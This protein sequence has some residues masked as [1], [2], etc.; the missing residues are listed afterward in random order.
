MVVLTLDQRVADLAKFPRQIFLEEER[1]DVDAL[2]LVL[3]ESENEVVP[4]FYK[5]DWSKRQ[6]K[7]EEP[8]FVKS[9]SLTN[10][11]PI[12]LA[13]VYQMMLQSLVENGYFVEEQEM[14]SILLQPLAANVED[15][16]IYVD[17]QIGHLKKINSP[18]LQ[19]QRVSDTERGYR[20]WLTEYHTINGMRVP[21]VLDTKS[22]KQLRGMFMGITES[23]KIEK[24]LREKLFVELFYKAHVAMLPLEFNKWGEKQTHQLYEKLN[25]WYGIGHQPD[26][27]RV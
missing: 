20:D 11:Q 2:E 8:V 15:V 9:D 14:N 5:Y 27:F 18:L 16:N 19:R 7:S 21:P 3:I 4:N 13:D 23:E 24:R 22:L 12:R 26:L 10:G 17:N 25:R 6:R 1:R